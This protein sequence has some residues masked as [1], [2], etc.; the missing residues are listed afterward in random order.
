MFFFF[1]LNTN[2]LYGDTPITQ[3][4]MS[5]P[6]MTQTNSRKVIV[7]SLSISLGVVTNLLISISLAH[8]LDA[9]AEDLQ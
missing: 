5:R 6:P 7:V 2:L 9:S 4:S 1:I 8:W 3:P